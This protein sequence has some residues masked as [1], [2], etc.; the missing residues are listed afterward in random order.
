M[1]AGDFARKIK[2]LN[3][4][5]KIA[6]GNDSS[7]PASLFY[8]DRQG[9]EESICGIDK[10]II[11]EW[12]VMNPNGSYHKSGWRR[13]LRVLIGR[14]LVDRYEAE[15]L[16]RTDLNYK[17]PRQVIKKPDLGVQIKGGY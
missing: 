2:K 7:R 12:P 10:N 8:V 11:P 6:C 3:R 16:F 4:N 14:G 5:L 9:H 13:T 17:R 1:L 15:K